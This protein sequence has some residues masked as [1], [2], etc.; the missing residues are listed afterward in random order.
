MKIK[1]FFKSLLAGMGIGV[2]SAIPGV[3]GG[4]IAVSLKVYDKIISA[5]SGIFKHFK[6]SI[7]VLLPILLGVVL[8][9]IPCIYLFD[10]AFEGFV[11]G[12]VTLFAGL[13]VG[14]FP[15][16]LKEVKNEKVTSKNIIT[17]IITLLI[18]LAIGVLSVN[19]GDTINISSHFA[20]P[21]W[22]F[23][24]LLIP[25]GMIA[26][27]ALVVPGISGSMIL[28][29]LGFYTPLLEYINIWAKEILSGNFTNFLVCLLV[30]LCF[31]IGVILGVLLVSKVMALLLK[32]FRTITFY[33]I[34]GFIIGSTITLFY[35]NEI[36]NYYS[37]WANNNYVWIPMYLEIILGII[38][39]ILGALGVY[40]LEK[41][42]EKIKEQ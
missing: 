27:F 36:V 24:L 4:T 26:S 32:K 42:N 22:W 1:N 23:Y 9:L 18:A 29:I 34:I 30:L 6:E 38:L 35:N 20:S 16:I 11:F 8:A 28:L 7:K 15:G 2:A 33:G 19:L 21:E 12:I 25:V 41:H 14:S 40:F 31:A 13:I 17:L 10:K 3:S 37:I 5:V 39:F